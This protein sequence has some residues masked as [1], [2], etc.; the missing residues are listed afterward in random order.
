MEIDEGALIEFTQRLVR[1]RSVN[2]AGFREAPA[3]QLVIDLADRWGWSYEVQPVA[4]ERPN[5]IITIEG[6]QPGPT[7]LFEG[8]SDVVTEGDVSQWTVDPYGGEIIDD[9][10]YGR[11]SADMKA[12]VACMLFAARAIEQSGPFPGRIKLAVLCDE[13]EMMI[14]V[15]HFVDAGG[16]ADVDAAIVCEPEGFEICA[17]QKGAI[18]L[19]V[20]L[21]G[22][23]AHGAMPHKGRNPI[24]AAALF[25]AGLRD[26]EIDVQHDLGEHPHLGFTYLTPTHMDAGSLP[27]INVL[28]GA[29][30][31]TYDIRTIPGVDHHELLAR[32]E[33]VGDAITDET[34]VSFAYTVLVDRPP[35]ETPQDH[36]VVRAIAQ[37]HESVTGTTAVYGG[38]P[39]TTDG[40]IL[41]RDGGLPVVVYGPGGKWIAHQ[42]DEYVEV[43]ELGTYA[44]VYADA[45]RRFFNDGAVVTQ[46]PPR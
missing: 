46:S 24:T 12:G 40:T 9:K 22:Q 32:I 2:E 17:V 6:G 25:I 38:V 41:W 26:I 20:D 19:R 5:V 14:G 18:R 23:M 28:P 42:A 15:H 8:H 36:P 21:T 7:L 10:L 3:A 39:G 16:V 29:A 27:Q 4:P 44:R 33:Q 34:G 13:E 45:A 11:G 1:V 30:I 35:T 37:A 31:L 43:A